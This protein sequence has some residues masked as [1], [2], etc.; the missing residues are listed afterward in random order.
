MNLLLSLPH[1]GQYDH[2][3]ASSYRVSISPMKTA[4]VT[5]SPKGKIR[6]DKINP[7]DTGGLEK[8]EALEKLAG[9]REKIAALQEVFYAENRRSVLLIFQAMDT[10][11]KDGS[12][13][14]LC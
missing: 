6:L 1:P 8:E 5:A 9:L 11:G 4:I 10:G 2:Q 3:P 14:N 13:K 7:D 12:I